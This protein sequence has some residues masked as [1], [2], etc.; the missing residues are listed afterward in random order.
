MKDIS[1]RHDA[2]VFD[3][4][5]ILQDS[6]LGIPTHHILHCWVKANVLPSTHSTKLGNAMGKVH[7]EDGN[8]LDDF[9]ACI[10]SMQAM[11]TS[12]IEGLNPEDK[13][14]HRSLEILRK[15][16]CNDVW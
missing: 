2:H 8:A 11:D 5:S 3:A 7:I 13:D 6:W 4:T 12:S 1:E 10:N 15:E 16:D 14:V 9:Q